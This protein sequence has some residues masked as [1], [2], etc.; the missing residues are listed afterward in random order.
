MQSDRHFLLL[1]PPLLESLPVPAAPLLI[2]TLTA[3]RVPVH[4]HILTVLS[5]RGIWYT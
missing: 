4:T 5:M 2:T 3:V 1:F